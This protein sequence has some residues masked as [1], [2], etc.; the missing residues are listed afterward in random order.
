MAKEQT[1]FSSRVDVNDQRFLA[2]ESMVKE[3]QNAC[4][5]TGQPVPQTAGELAAVI[6]QSLAVSY[7][8]AAEEIEQITGRK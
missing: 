1:A 3:V 7:C 8:K 2:P 4:Q 5:E 6:Y